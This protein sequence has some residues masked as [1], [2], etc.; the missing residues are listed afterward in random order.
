VGA[1]DVSSHVVVIG[2]GVVGLCAAH[3][4]LARGFRVTVI[5]READST[6]GCSYGNGGIVVP[7]HFV[8][9][10]APGMV[11]MGLNMMANPKSPFGIHGLFN[12]EVLSWVVRFMRAGTKT[13]VERCA[14]VL[15]DMNLASRG[16]YEELIDG[17]PEVGFEKRGLLMLC[18]TQKALD[19]EAHL[20]AD[21]NRLG[22][23]ARVLGTQEIV[24]MEPDALITVDGGVH[25]EE[26]AHLTPAAFMRWMRA[27]V[28]ESGGE[29]R[30]AVEVIGLETEGL[31]VTSVQTSQGVIEAD[32][33]V[34]AAGVW[35][36]KI[37]AS[38]GL[39][40]PM[41]SGKG[42]G[43][44]VASPPERLRLP[45]ILVEDR[46]AVT[47]MTD[48]I[49][50]VG[51]MELGRPNSILNSKRVEGMKESIPFYYPAYN[52]YDIGAVPVWSGHR[53]CT[54]DGMPY[55][56]RSSRFDNLTLA[57]GHAMMGMSL[58][59]ISGRLVAQVVAGDKPSIPLALLSPDRYA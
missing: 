44:T 28:V 43:F 7:S 46:I 32:E 8:P 9:L 34:L 1:G 38:A 21:A 15:R 6:T 25:F 47:P 3:E 55:L 13:H 54:P 10:A 31:R 48:G 20:A 29:I 24:A 50:F 59:P 51:T 36:G 58:G 57:A 33:V 40:L 2:A 42:Y 19:G 22:L 18:R 56:G 30:D 14:P 39:N 45:A 4:L 11:A 41:L 12:L 37:G 16:I 52:N 17:I 27:K 23:T 49:R 5:E 26:D 53:P 35:S